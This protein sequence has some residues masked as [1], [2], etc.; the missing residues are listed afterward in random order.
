MLDEGKFEL[1][2]TISSNLQKVRSM[3]F[4]LTSVCS[5]IELM[6]ILPTDN[7]NLTTMYLKST[8]I[9]SDN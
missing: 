9:T 2:S 3:T 6:T 7:Q 1:I 8:P 5:S 4:E